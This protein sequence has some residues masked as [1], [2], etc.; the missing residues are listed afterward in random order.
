MIVVNSNMKFIEEHIFDFPDAL[1]V[2]VYLGCCWFIHSFLPSFL[3]ARIHSPTVIEYL[4]N[5]P[6]LGKEDTQID[7]RVNHSPLPGIKDPWETEGTHCPH[8]RVLVSRRE[9]GGLRSTG[10]TWAGTK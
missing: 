7:N 4:L 9:A 2:A 1:P 10:V 8:H 5:R 6:V 3:Y